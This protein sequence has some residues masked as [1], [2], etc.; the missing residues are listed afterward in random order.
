MGD[1]SEYYRQI[2]EIRKAVRE[3]EMY[4]LELEN[5]RLLK[6]QRREKRHEEL[7]A[8]VKSLHKE[9]VREELE[10][11]Q[12]VRKLLSQVE[13]VTRE[14]QLL[15]AQTEKLRNRKQQYE[16]QLERAYPNLKSNSSNFYLN[17]LYQTGLRPGFIPS[18]ASASIFPQGANILGNFPLGANTSGSMLQRASTPMP[19]SSMSNLN[20]FCAAVPQVSPI[21]PSLAPTSH[22]S[23]QQP[24][25]SFASGNMASQVTSN[26][27]TVP[28]P[29]LHPG[30]PQPSLNLSQQE[31]ANRNVNLRNGGLVSSASSA[32]PVVTSQIQYPYQENAPQPPLSEQGG[33]N[34]SLSNPSSFVARSLSMVNESGQLLPEAYH[35][36]A[37]VPSD[38]PFH[39]DTQPSHTLTSQGI[40]NPVQNPVD[41]YFD[42]LSLHSMQRKSA[43]NSVPT[44]RTDTTSTAP[45]LEPIS[46]SQNYQGISTPNILEN[47]EI[48]IKAEE[49][50]IDPAVPSH[51]E[52]PVINNF[53]RL[54]S[55]LSEEASTSTGLP[56]RPTV[57]G[58]SE[59]HSIDSVQANNEMMD[60]SLPLSPQEQA[61]SQG[62]S[63]S[64]ELSSSTVNNKQ[65]EISLGKTDSASNSASRDLS[66]HGNSVDSSSAYH[67]RDK[68]PERKPE[69]A[70]KQLISKRDSESGGTE[71]QSESNTKSESE[72]AVK[73]TNETNDSTKIAA[74]KENTA[75]IHQQKDQ[76]PDSKANTT[77]STSTGNSNQKS[78]PSAPSTDERSISNSKISSLQ[79]KDSSLTST[80]SDIKAKNETQAP[81]PTPHTDTNKPNPSE[82][83]KVSVAQAV[84][85]ADPIPKPDTSKVQVSQPS[86]SSLTDT[87]S[88]APTPS[89]P[90]KPSQPKPFAAR[91][92]DE[93]S[94]F[95]DRD[96]PVTSTAAYKAMVSGTRAPS[97]GIPTESDSDD[98]E[99]Q[100]SA[101]VAKRE[102]PKSRP[103]FKPFASSIPSL[104]PAP[105]ST[106]TDSVD[107][108]E[109]AIQA[110][111]NKP[112]DQ[113]T[114]EKPVPPPETST[115]PSQAE[116][117][118]GIKAA[119]A[120]APRALLG[121]T[122]PSAALQ[123][124]LDSDSE[125]GGVSAGAEASDEDDFDFYD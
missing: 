19:A 61:P 45:P 34:T 49:Q 29:L 10:A 38:K 104:R 3:R 1:M 14:H 9:L 99:N 48:K 37:G 11:A 52:A 101:M 124:N 53:S 115:A 43:A 109:A 94:D 62:G 65:G 18:A 71:K 24:G 64:N 120:P 67:I 114:G 112:K 74:A 121:K 59:A 76:K 103:A 75:G 96:V 107:S 60:E 25:N 12:R 77:P 97:T 16:A 111:M 58:L 41:V 123:L 106:D 102:V 113:V 31:L 69:N 81:S 108:V 27:M 6:T 56:T 68:Q 21:A 26:Q 42:T 17:D 95:F 47:P 98:L 72:N 7:R 87:S 5:E 92:P 39:Q 82:P 122:R 119:S 63:G 110:A 20:P 86:V 33:F 57:T 91:D 36:H 85:K 93:D 4:R 35:R 50:Q 28:Q 23:V 80:S 32:V 89:L 105:P 78:L 44:G 90:V 22:G 84:K 51:N 116:N 83:E 88:T 100:M 46:T 40:A 125:S 117:P 55:Q 66:S 13:A 73:I 79:S 30:V 54:A 8:K 118:K 70:E 15:E 2:S